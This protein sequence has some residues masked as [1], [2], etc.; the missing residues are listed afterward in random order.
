MNRKIKI[1]H[2]PRCSKSR[3]AL[4]LL[5]E[6]ATDFEVVEYL[7][8]IPTVEE[9]TEVIKKLDINPIDLVR[10]GEEV[11]KTNFK[12][13]TLSDTEWIEAM[14]AYPKLI[15]RPIVIKDGKAILGRPPENVL[16]LI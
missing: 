5:E 13:K 10:R 14:V 8:K 1:Y 16:D 12:G 9:L 4:H 3:Q 11:F 2:N 15:E 7:K 6:S